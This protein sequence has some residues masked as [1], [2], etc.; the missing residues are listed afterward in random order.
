[1]KTIWLK[2]G[3]LPNDCHRVSTPTHHTLLKK[4][5]TGIREYDLLK[6][7]MVFILGQKF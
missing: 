4:L 7:V 1:M 3:F 5:H 2:D 6:Y